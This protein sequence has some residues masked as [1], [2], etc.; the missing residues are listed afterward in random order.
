[1]V[2]HLLR[3]ALDLGV[4]ALHRVEVERGG[5]AAG[6]HA[7]RRAAAHADAHARAAELDQQ[8]AGGEFF[9]V[10]LRVA[11]GAEAA[12]DHD[13]LVI[14]ALHA[15]HLLLVDAKVAAEIGPAELVV[16]R[17]AAERALGHDL[18]R[19]GDVLG[20][21]GAVLLP[22]LLQTGQVQVAHAEAGEAGLRA[23]AAAH[24]AFVAD[25]A[26]GAGARA[27]ERRDR[28]RVVVRLHLHQHVRGFGARLV[29]R[30]VGEAA[31]RPALDGAAAHHRG[32]VAVG[33][34]RALRAHLLGV[35]DHLEHRV[36]LRH[37]V[38][39]EARV[40]DLVPAVFAVGLREH[41]QLHVRSGCAS[42]C[43]RRRRAGNRSR[44]R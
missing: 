37:A 1:M 28:G 33:R 42:A 30:R 26:A 22:R 35:A 10:R 15:G 19:A 36:F 41:H 16:E 2:D 4:A 39:R 24:R 44:R 13:R 14:A 23:R 31:R 27:G 38:D 17:G 7:A 43:A 40:E 6:G 12:R 25:L 9:L 32:V 8:R 29:H 20:L 18:Q 21:A 5:V 3:A 34:D 11:H